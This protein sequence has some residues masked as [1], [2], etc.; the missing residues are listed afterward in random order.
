MTNILKDQINLRQN[1]SHDYT[2]SYHH[3]WTARTALRGG[4]VAAAIHHAATT[5][6][7]LRSPSQTSP[8]FWLT[9][10]MNT[11]CQHTSL[12][13]FCRSLAVC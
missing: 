2:V 6:L 9:S 11:G 13:E 5:H 12:V 7:I 3:D 4:A 10:L 8:G 1:T